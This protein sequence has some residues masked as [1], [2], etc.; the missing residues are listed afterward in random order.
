MNLSTASLWF[1][2]C[3]FA[4]EVLPQVSILYYWLLFYSNWYT[5]L[6]CLFN[7]FI[8][9]EFTCVYMKSTHIANF[10]PKISPIFW[11][12]LLKFSF[13][14]HCFVFWPLSNNIFLYILVFVPGACVLFYCSICLLCK[15]CSFTNKILVH[16]ILHLKLHRYYIL[17]LFPG[18]HCL[19]ILH[20]Y[21]Y[22]NFC[23]H[24]IDQE[25]ELRVV[26][27]SS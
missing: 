2:Y 19:S 24:F 8:H 3:S 22:F 23:T 5:V 14:P 7:A 18:I 13:C 16:F 21:Q 4:F 15:S 26:K 1:C 17:V 25:T 12:H 9:K 20:Q 6:P 11:N 27:P 10:F